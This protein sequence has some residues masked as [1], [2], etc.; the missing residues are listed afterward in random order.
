MTDPTTSTLG[1]AGCQSFHVPEGR[2][3][4]A[5]HDEIGQGNWKYATVEEAKRITLDAR[6]AGP[7]LHSCHYDSD[8]APPPFDA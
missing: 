5:I 1:C 6:K 2:I 7:C 3:E 8:N 4:E